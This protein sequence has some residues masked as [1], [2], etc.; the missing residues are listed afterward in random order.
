[1]KFNLFLSGLASQITIHISWNRSCLL[2]TLIFLKMFCLLFRRMMTMTFFFPLPILA[3]V[4]SMRSWANWVEG[5]GTMTRRK[6]LRDRN[7]SKN[8]RKDRTLKISKILSGKIEFP[9]VSPG[10]RCNF[11]IKVFEGD[12]FEP[13]VFSVDPVCKEELNLMLKVSDF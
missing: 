13:S 4:L 2:K 7:L 5:V 8:Q 11:W 12:P 1:M 6:I 3:S 9:K 10:I